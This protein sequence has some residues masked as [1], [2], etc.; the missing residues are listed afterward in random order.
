MA[1][2]PMG[3]RRGAKRRPTLPISRTFIVKECEECSSEWVE[4]RRRAFLSST[5]SE[6]FWGAEQTALKRGD[7]SKVAPPLRRAYTSGLFL[8][9]K[10]LHFLL[11]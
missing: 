8:E 9:I 11:E 1:K 10:G 4:G 2:D 7:D 5:E 6:K 3:G